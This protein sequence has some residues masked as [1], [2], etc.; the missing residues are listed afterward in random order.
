M[1]L[2]LDGRN[3]YWYINSFIPQI[4]SSY[5]PRICYHPCMKSHH[6]YTFDIFILEW[7]YTRSINR[8]NI[9]LRKVH[10]FTFLLCINFLIIISTGIHRI[11]FVFSSIPDHLDFIVLYCLRTNIDEFKNDPINIIQE[12]LCP[13]IFIIV[14]SIALRDI[15]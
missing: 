9:Q 4:M 14:F 12:L 10:F 1:S 11:F 6:T 2:I 15:T 13:I 7:G 3:F 8:K 5:T